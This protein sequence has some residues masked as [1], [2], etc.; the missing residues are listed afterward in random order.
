MCIGYAI[1]RWPTRRNIPPPLAITM[2]YIQQARV[3]LL[4]IENSTLRPKFKKI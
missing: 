1:G 2:Y 4:L 3:E